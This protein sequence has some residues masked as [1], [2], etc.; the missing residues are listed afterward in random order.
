MPKNFHEE[1]V[2]LFERLKSGQKF[3]FSKYADGEWAVINDKQLNNNEFE[4]NHDARFSLARKML[5]DSFLFKDKGYYVGISCECC[6]GAE[7]FKMKEFCGQDDEH[8]TYAN[9][10]VNSNYQFY[11]D[12]FIP[13]YASR[14]IHLVANKNSKIENLP[15]SVEKFYPIENSAYINNSSLVEEIK[16]ENLKDKLF[17][18][19]AGPF[20][21]ILAHKLFSENKNN[22]YLDIG[23]TLNPWLQSEGFKRGY[24]NGEFYANQ[25]CI[26][27]E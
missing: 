15:F 2:K 4:Y 22:T 13:E 7:H 21:N 25:T 9:I 17:L 19:C 20:G 5:I 8:L 16:G 14:K 11:K 27:R 18:F 26:W 10:F 23:S 6:Q 1:I 3:A 12:N 24:Y